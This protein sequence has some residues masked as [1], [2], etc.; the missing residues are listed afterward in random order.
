MGSSIKNPLT[1]YGIEVKTKL[2][3]MGKTQNWLIDQ[4]KSRTG[5]FIDCSR[6]NKIITGRSNSDRI[7]GAIND[8]LGI[9]T[10]EV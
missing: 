6:L 7:V 4:V 1:D 5:M 3:S 2:I 10:N 8:I 9:N